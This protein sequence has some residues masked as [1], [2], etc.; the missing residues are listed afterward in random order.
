M[1]SGANQTPLLDSP[2]S[3]QS[4]HTL[5]GDTGTAISISTPFELQ[6]MFFARNTHQSPDSLL[7][8]MATTPP[9]EMAWA[10]ELSKKSLLAPRWTMQAHQPRPQTQ[11]WQD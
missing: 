2:W 11:Q 4:V 10:A 3:A 6:Q 7:L 5:K 1:S 8:E 9:N